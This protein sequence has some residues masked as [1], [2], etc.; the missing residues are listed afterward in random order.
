MISSAR[1]GPAYEP[2]PS[3]VSA[4]ASTCMPRVSTTSA[5]IPT[6]P[7]S[8]APAPSDWAPWAS[9]VATTP[10]TRP[11]TGRADMARAAAARSGTPVRPTG[12]TVIHDNARRTASNTWDQSLSLT[13]ASAKVAISVRIAIALCTTGRAAT[14]PLPSPRCM[15]WSRTGS[16]ER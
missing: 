8:S 7:L 9:A 16:S 6:T 13:P 14:A 11:T 3:A 5:P 2:S 10:H 1:S 15:E 12:R 4:N